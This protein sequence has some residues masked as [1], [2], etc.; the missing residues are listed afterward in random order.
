[1]IAKR[2]LRTHVP[3]KPTWL[4][5]LDEICH[6]LQSLPS[7]TLDRQTLEKILGLRSRRVQQLMA[8]VVTQTIG[9]NGI[10]DRD[11]LIRHLRSVASGDAAHYEHQ[12]RAKLGSVLE[13][14]RRS[15]L[16]QP[17]VLVEA[18]TEVVNQE[19]ADLPN[20]VHLGPGRILLEFETKEQ[21]FAQLLA[22]VMAIGNDPDAF[23]S[24]IQSKPRL[25]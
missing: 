24:R 21:A 18:S 22:L 6:E 17:R 15:W 9:R 10:V 7:S 25:S 16:E 13:Q 23:E 1:M 3:D 19:I 20:G 5:R 12:R 4:G 11:Q 2:L 14:L 8:P